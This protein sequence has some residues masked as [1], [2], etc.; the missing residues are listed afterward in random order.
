[1]IAAKPEFTAPKSMISN[2]GF[3]VSALILEIKSVEKSIIPAKIATPQSVQALNKMGL[4]VLKCL[5]TIFTLKPY[6]KEAK[7]IK[8]A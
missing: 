2:K 1:M 8:S 4:I 7:M 5:P 6:I 3:K